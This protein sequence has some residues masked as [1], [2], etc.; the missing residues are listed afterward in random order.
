MVDLDDPGGTRRAAEIYKARGAPPTLVVI[1]GSVPSQRAQLWWRLDEPD[2]DAAHVRT[3]LGALQ[4][5]FTS[6]ASVVDPARI[7][8]FGGSIAWPIFMQGSWSTLPT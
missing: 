3:M 6:D 8:R 1:T 4:T 7:L 5:A 2:A